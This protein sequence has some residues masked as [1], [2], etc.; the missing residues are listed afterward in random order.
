MKNKDEFNEE[1]NFEFTSDVDIEQLK[2]TI[3]ESEV[4]CEI[5][6]S[7]EEELEGELR[8]KSKG[9]IVVELE[10]DEELEAKSNDEIQFSVED[11][12][13]D[14]EYKAKLRRHRRIRNEIIARS[15]FVIVLLLMVV[16]IYLLANS[17]IKVNKDKST[18]L[19]ESEISETIDIEDLLG[20][21]ESET[22]ETVETLVEDSAQD[23]FDDYLDTI[24]TSMTLEEKI[25]GLIITSPERLTGV[26][27]V[28]AA[29][30]ATQSALEQYPI[31][32]LIYTRKNMQSKEQF[33]EMIENINTYSKY[34]LLLGV[35]EERSEISSVKNSEIGAP[36]V[37]DVSDVVATND[38]AT[39][40]QQGLDIATY[41]SELGLN[42]NLAPVADVTVGGDSYTANR[43]YGSDALITSDLIAQVAKGLEEG[44]VSATLKSFPGEGAITTN[45]EQSL[46]TS[47]R[48]KEEFNS[49]DFLPYR[50]GIDMG[51]DFIMMSSMIPEGI[52]NDTEYATFSKV[53]VSD[54]LRGELGYKGVV[55]SAPLNTPAFV[56]YK[57]AGESAVASLKAGCDMIYMPQGVSESI[58]AVAEAITSGTISQ[59]RIDD[60]IKRVLAVKYQ[61]KLKEFE[62]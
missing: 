12:V 21:E 51:V 40:Y 46:T 31:G 17:F 23:L 45:P 27:Q 52:T 60:S 50:A 1:I 30:P 20:S 61:E 54:I 62:E 19:A 26:A 38:K 29:G 49:T 47:K 3:E 32:G 37:S 43:A 35:T 2:K 34:P 36:D 6:E 10:E 9:K 56:E 41:L 7:I 28:T 18:E 57:T 33:T 5:E 59:E 11:E 16:G 8:E 48:T 53:I 55:I 42:L 14:E 24:I 15:S 22:T 13:Q 58:S 4:E 39:A 25:A 44:G